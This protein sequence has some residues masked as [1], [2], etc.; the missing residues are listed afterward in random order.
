MGRRQTR[1]MD[2]VMKRRTVPVAGT[3][4]WSFSPLDNAQTCIIC[5]LHGP[6]SERIN[7]LKKFGVALELPGQKASMHGTERSG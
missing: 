3:E 2:E 6:K 5:S 7:I 1:G 4:P